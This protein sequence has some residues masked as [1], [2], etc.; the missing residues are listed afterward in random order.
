MKQTLKKGPLHGW[1]ALQDGGKVA[2]QEGKN[3]KDTI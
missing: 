1:V 2:Y 3:P